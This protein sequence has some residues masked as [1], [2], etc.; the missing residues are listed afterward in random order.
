MNFVTGSVMYEKHTALVFDVVLAWHSEIVAQSHHACALLH[1]APSL[2][3][4][5]IHGII[6]AAR[7]MFFHSPLP[8]SIPFSILHSPLPVRVSIPGSRFFRASTVHIPPSFPLFA[9]T[10]LFNQRSQPCARKSPPS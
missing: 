6:P 9:S 1:S 7:R 4:N 10:S 8:V 3:P 5:V 2:L